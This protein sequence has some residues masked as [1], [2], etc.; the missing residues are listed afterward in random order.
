VFLCYSSGDKAQVRDLYY[1]LQHDG[2]R[3]WLDEEDLLPGQDW[4]H[5]ITQAVRTSIAVLVCLSKASISEAGFVQKEIKRA[6]DVADEQPDG[7]IF[8]IP[9]K[10]EDCDVP[11]SLRRWHWVNLFDNGGYDKLMQVLTRAPAR[12]EKKTQILDEPSER[13]WL[14]RTAP[15]WQRLFALGTLAILAMWLISIPVGDQLAKVGGGRSS[16]LSATANQKEAVLTAKKYYDAKQFEQALPLF[17]SAALAGNA[18]AAD[19]IGKMYDEGQGQL[20]PKDEVQA[21]NWFRKAAEAGYGDGMVHLGN[22]YFMGVGGWPQD[23]VQAVE[24]YRRGQCG[25]YG[26]V[27]SPV[28][29]GRR[30]CLAE[31]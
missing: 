22:V 8:L 16:I 14:W 23:K 30:R 1:R 12:E 3:P 24:W 13:R 29:P 10:I 27:G 17:R 25:R 20:L 7:S 2:L 31:R 15:K 21:A 26:D 28:P 11:E 18:E 5:E 4:D 9:V 6:L 19:Y